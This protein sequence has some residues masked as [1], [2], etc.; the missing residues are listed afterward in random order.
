MA[1]FP[2][3]YVSFFCVGQSSAGKQASGVA[4][5]QG[6]DKW[7]FRIEGRKEEREQGHDHHDS[8]SRGEGA[9]RTPSQPPFGM[10]TNCVL[11]HWK[12]NLL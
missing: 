6:K 8:A 11:F 10:V 12:A 7:D 4:D 3:D 9:K 2:R 1:I 5:T